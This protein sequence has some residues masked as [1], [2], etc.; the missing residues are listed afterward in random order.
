M[1]PICVVNLRKAA[2]GSAGVVDLSD[3]LARTGV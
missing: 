1:C 2:D 3:S